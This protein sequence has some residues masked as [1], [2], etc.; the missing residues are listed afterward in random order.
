M[1]YDAYRLSPKGSVNYPLPAANVLFGLPNP[2]GAV[3][4]NHSP[5]Y[6]PEGQ[7]HRADRGISV[8]LSPR[9]ALPLTEPLPHSLSPRVP[10]LPPLPIT[11]YPESPMIPIPFQEGLLPIEEILTPK[12]YRGNAKYAAS[13]PGN[14]M[15]MNQTV[16][17]PTFEYPKDLTR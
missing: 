9:P 3:P 7:G 1:L 5:L 11:V 14:Y 4:T 8:S 2:A 16:Q 17:S 13:N 15:G 12:P 6:L 10:E